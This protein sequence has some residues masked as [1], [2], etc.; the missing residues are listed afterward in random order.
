MRNL[1]VCLC[2]SLIT[3]FAVVTAKA[4]DALSMN[5][6]MRT[7]SYIHSVYDGLD[8]TGND[9]L[10]YDA[11]AAAYKGYL[12]LKEEGK[13]NDDKQ[14][15]TVCDFNLSSNNKRMWIIDLQNGKILFNTYVAHGMASGVEYATSFSNSMDSH[16]SS[17][18]FYVTGDTYNGEHG[19]SLRLN[20]M[21][22]GFN[23]A[24]LARGVVVHGARYV[25]D[26]FITGN[27]RLGRSWGCP[28][29]PD[30][31]KEPIINTI[32]NG[33]CMFIYR[34]DKKY[35]KS[36]RW[37]NRTLAYL[38]EANFD[39]LVQIHKKAP[40]TTYKVQYIHNGKVD[41]VKTISAAAATLL[42]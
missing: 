1:F 21:D 11:F 2:A 13:L 38:P 5:M 15:L 10:S 37:L 31:L 4:G 34:T 40:Q 42:R 25:C 30:D 6:E 14:I 41:S 20:G 23:S 7:A 28:A 32:K 12:N 22:N 18:G 9:I 39:E 8:F 26:N 29:V 33:T 3:C 27:T 35:A 24:A 16:Q 17:L 36:S 19:T